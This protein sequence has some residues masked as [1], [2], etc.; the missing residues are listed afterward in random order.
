MNKIL[1]YIE[2][3]VNEGAKLNRWKEAYRSGTF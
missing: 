1:S 2:V 3:G